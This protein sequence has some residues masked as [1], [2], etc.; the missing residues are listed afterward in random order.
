M[1]A[2]KRLVSLLGAAAS[3]LLCSPEAFG[4]FWMKDLRETVQDA[5]RVIRGKVLRGADVRKPAPQVALLRVLKHFK[6]G[7]EEQ[8]EVEIEKTTANPG[9]YA[10]RK[11]EICY[12]CLSK[13]GEKPGVYQEINFGHSKFEVKEGEVDLGKVKVP[14]SLKFLLPDRKEKTFENALAW[15]AGPVLSVKTA[16]KSYRC[17]QDM[18]FDVTLTNRSRI[19]MKIPFGKK[20]ALGSHFDL[21]LVGKHGFYAVIQ[22]YGGYDKGSEYFPDEEKSILASLD[23]GKSAEGRIRFRIPLDRYFQDPENIRHAELRYSPRKSGALQP[24][25]WSGHTSIRLP[26]EVDC[27][28]RDWAETLMRPNSAAAVALEAP[29][30]GSPDRPLRVT[31][32]VNRCKAGETHGGYLIPFQ[33]EKGKKILAELAR[34]FEISRDGKVLQASAGDRELLLEFIESQPSFTIEVDLSEVFDFSKPGEY[35]LR[36]HLPGS[37]GFSVSQQ[38]RVRIPNRKD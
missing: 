33:G 6:P 1:N 9:K 5:D 13:L 28:Y 23:P 14:D 29:G 8:L 12:L 20:L 35:S 37:D 26:I 27:P 15:I 38:V 19:P 22:A 17:D 18:F 21:S 7:G 2:R 36:F 31:V 10:L 24:H 30:V 3:I 34:C 4:M 32:N 11:G 25:Q 16:E